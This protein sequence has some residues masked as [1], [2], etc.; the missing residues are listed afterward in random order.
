[1]ASWHHVQVLF[2]GKFELGPGRELKPSWT[3]GWF[4]GG[5]DAAAG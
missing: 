5:L 1:M 4:V 3:L 2:C